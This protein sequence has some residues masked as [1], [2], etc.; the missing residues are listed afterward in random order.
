MGR[1][2]QPDSEG[3]QAELLHRSSIILIPAWIASHQVPSD[4]EYYSA[5]SQVAHSFITLPWQLYGRPISVHSRLS[6]VIEADLFYQQFAVWSPPKPGGRHF[7][8]DL[9]ISTYHIVILQILLSLFIIY[10]LMWEQP[11]VHIALRSKSASNRN[12]RGT[13]KVWKNKCRVE[14]PHSQSAKCNKDRFHYSD[15]GLIGCCY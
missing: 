11:L 7:L 6:L 2:G 15:L 9:P 5:C 3:Q 4:A 14:S 12:T 1:F 13:S 10:V 8:P